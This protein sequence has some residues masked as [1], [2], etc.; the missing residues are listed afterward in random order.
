MT[1]IEFDEL[2]I[3]TCFGQRFVEL[4]GLC[5][6]HRAIEGPMQQTHAQVFGIVERSVRANELP[7]WRIVFLE[8]FR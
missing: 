7:Q 6:R 5:E 2:D 3:V 1:L 8:R 4:H